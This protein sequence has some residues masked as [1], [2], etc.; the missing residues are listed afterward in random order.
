MQV[1]AGNTHSRILYVYDIQ[2]GKLSPMHQVRVL[3]E[4]I[5]R[6]FEV[7]PDGPFM[8]IHGIAGDSYLLAMKTK[9]L[10]GSMKVTEG[11][12]A[13]VFTSDSKKI[14]TYAGDQKVYV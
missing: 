2:A 7:S 13:S 9:E 5:L 11:V 14:H 12:S 4:R 8:L 1:L 3:K 10:I 6:T